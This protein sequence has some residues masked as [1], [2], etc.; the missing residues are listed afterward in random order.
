[1]NKE[2]LDVTVVSVK[3]ESASLKDEAVILPIDLSIE[4]ATSLNEV[5]LSRDE[6]YIDAIDNNDDVF[7][8]MVFAR[9]VVD[10]SGKLYNFTFLPLVNNPSKGVLLVEESFVNGFVIYD[11][12]KPWLMSKGL[13]KVIF[14][15]YPLDSGWDIQ[16]VGCYIE[17]DLLKVF[18]KD[19]DLEDYLIELPVFEYD[20]FNGT[21]FDRNMIL[22]NEQKSSR[23]VKSS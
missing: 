10:K 19:S 1:M 21:E 7:M 6:F 9:G 4:E 13:I 16:D 23:K 14:S 5:F 3:E 18:T 20:L 2:E 8:A 11:L 17:G 15:L 12:G 22:E